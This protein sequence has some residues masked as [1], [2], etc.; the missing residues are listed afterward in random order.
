LVLS[1]RALGADGQVLTS[2]AST[3]RLQEFV[4]LPEWPIVSE[5]GPW[6]QVIE[7]TNPG[8]DSVDLNGWELVVGREQSGEGFLTHA[9]LRFPFQTPLASGVALTWSGIGVPPGAFP[10]RVSAEPF[11]QPLVQIRQRLGKAEPLEVPSDQHSEEQTNDCSHP[12]PIVYE[13]QA[14]GEEISVGRPQRPLPPLSPSDS[15]WNSPEP[16]VSVFIIWPPCP[17]PRNRPPIPNLIG[18]ESG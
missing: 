12:G 9:R 5:V 16:P 4:K 13:Q 11:D 1:V 10:A 2:D 14:V 15:R 3:L 7:V 18:L 8:E 17:Y 6:G